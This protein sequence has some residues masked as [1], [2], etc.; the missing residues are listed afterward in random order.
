MLM[1]TDKIKREIKDYS[2]EFSSREVCGL[3]V[4][5]EKNVIFYKCLNISFHPNSD[6]ILSPLDYV[7]ASK[8]GKIIAHFHSHPTSGK[9]SFM[10]YLNSAAHSIYSLIYSI[11]LDRFFIIEPKLKDYL[12]LDYQIGK[13]DCFE[14]VRN[15]YENELNISLSNYHRYDKWEF[16]MPNLMLDNYEKE[17]FYKVDF[18]DIK[19]NDVI[20]FN[21]LG[22][23]SH[24][25]IYMGNN[26]I[27]HHPENDKSVICELSKSLSKR[28]EVVIRHKSLL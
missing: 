15:Y 7:R 8:L 14:L 3:L 27:L 11:K 25:G 16:D 13:N 23:A 10:D 26:F 1:L 9:P 12:N 18:K 24:L 20:I 2:K 19:E 5:N 22:F 28:I 17:G 21:I 6:C 4:G